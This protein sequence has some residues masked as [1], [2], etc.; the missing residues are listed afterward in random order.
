MSAAERMRRGLLLLVISAGL[1]GMAATPVAGDVVLNNDGAPGGLRLQNSGPTMSLSS[2]IIVERVRDGRWIETPVR[3]D[4]VEKCAVEDPP[5]CVSVAAGTTVITVP[6][7]G[8]NCS[9]QCPHSCRSNQYVGPGQ[10]RFVVKS[11][12]GTRTVTGPEFV[13]PAGN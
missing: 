12:D 11:C 2:K 13:M 1:S 3:M 7:R 4:L 8:N 9:G 6:W 10:F 5:V